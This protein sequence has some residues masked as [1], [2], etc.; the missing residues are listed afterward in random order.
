MHATTK[1]DPVDNYTP[2][3]IE[4][5]L[6]PRN[7]GEM[8]PEECSGFAL[9]ED[10]DCGDQMMLWIRVEGERIEDIRFKSFGCPGAIATCSMATDLAKGKTIQAALDLT[11]DDVIDA[12]GGIPDQ[13]RHCSLLGIRAIHL[14]IHDL[15]MR[16]LIQE[17]GNG[18]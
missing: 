12:L 3:A 6:N 15:L 17:S 7:I 14:A 1:S 9:V 13:K 18:E 8:T 4:H 11:D 2:K 16:R 5:F 10:D